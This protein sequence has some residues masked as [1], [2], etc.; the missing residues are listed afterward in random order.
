MAIDILVYCSEKYGLTNRVGNALYGKYNGY[1]IS[2]FE[3]EDYFNL[4][5]NYFL[6]ESQKDPIYE[7]LEKTKS[8][9][10][11][12]DVDAVVRAGATGMSIR[13]PKN[14]EGQMSFDESLK[15]YTQ[16]FDEQNFPPEQGVKESDKLKEAIQHPRVQVV[17][18]TASVNM[19][20]KINTLPPSEYA[21]MPNGEVPIDY[22]PNPTV[23]YEPEPPKYLT[24]IQIIKGTVGALI[25][26]LICSPLYVF[27]STVVAQGNNFRYESVVV[28]IAEFAVILGALLG[29]FLMKGDDRP[30][31]KICVV[32]AVAVAVSTF[33]LLLGLGYSLPVKDMSIFRVLSNLFSKM[34][35]NSS[36][37]HQAI[38]MII[39]SLIYD[40]MC[41]CIEFRVYIKKFKKKKTK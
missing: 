14:E 13:F 38:M 20:Y 26:A 22:N 1:G 16:Y 32:S 33:A 29:Y 19:I 8:D 12:T 4:N 41:L 15:A 21:V 10:A 25:G 40:A 35:L 3:A 23:P 30:I 11:L 31:P 9:T 2:V 17:A 18:P 24:V 37:K 5:I 7:L 34:R 39:M 28:I 27:A 36:L 6:D